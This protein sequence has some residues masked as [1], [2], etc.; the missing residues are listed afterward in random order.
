VLSLLL[1]GYAIFVNLNNSINAMMTS[2]VFFSTMT[3][4]CLQFAMA[5][6]SSIT[7][8]VMS[9]SAASFSEFPNNRKDRSMQNA[10]A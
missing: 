1:T 7:A 3:V 9:Q 5:I 8:N 10:V 6:Y 2:S 4:L